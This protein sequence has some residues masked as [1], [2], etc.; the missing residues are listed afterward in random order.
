MD[1][2]LNAQETAPNSVC[3]GSRFVPAGSRESLLRDGITERQGRGSR[4]AQAKAQT[5]VSILTVQARGFRPQGLGKI[6]VS[7]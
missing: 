7:H 3:A 5:T 1:S 4:P 6:R 2:A